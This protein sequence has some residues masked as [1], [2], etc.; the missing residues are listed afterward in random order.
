MTATGLPPKTFLMS[1]GGL[2]SQS[3]AFFKTPGIELLY[4]GVTNSKPSALA[5]VAFNS[6]SIGYA[7]SGFDVAVIQWYAFDTFNLECRATRHQFYRG[8]KQRAV[9]RATPQTARN[10]DYSRHGIVH[11]YAAEATGSLRFGTATR[12]AKNNETAATIARPAAM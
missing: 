7:F 6:D 3:I 8:P 9:E 11:R 2:E 5:I 10:P 12:F 1:D 4:S